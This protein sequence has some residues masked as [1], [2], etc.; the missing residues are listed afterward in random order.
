MKTSETVPHII[1]NTNVP[2]TGEEEIA[3]LNPATGEQIGSIPAGTPADA[4][5]AVKAAREAKTGW[6]RLPAAERAEFV[7]A[8]ARRMREHAREL[9]EL[10]TLENGKPFD[11]ALGGVEAG[12]GTLEQYAELGPLHRGKTLQ[13]NYMASDMMIYEPYGVA[14]A[15]VPWNDPIAIACGYLG[16]AL[17]TGNTVV[18]KP[19]EKTP[20]SAVRLVEM[21]ELPDGVLNL[22]L[23]DAR[24]GWP[25]VAHED[26]DLVL[27][28]GSVETGREIME[29]AGRQL[30]KAV[31]ELGGKD[32]I[33]VDAGVDPA[34]AAGE[35]A[36]GSFANT[37]QICTSVERIY[38]HESVADEFLR[39]LVACARALRVG[40]G[41]DPETEMGPLVDEGQRELVHRHVTQAVEAGGE[42]LCGG[43]IPDGPGFFYPPTVLSG[44][45]SGM[46]VVDEETF[47]P[48]AAV[49][50]VSSFDEA[51]EKANETTYGLAAVV[52]TPDP[53]HAARAW[54][55][56]SV[57]TVKINAVFGGAPGGAAEPRKAS[58]L[59]FGYG[60]ELLDEVTQTKVIHHAVA[61]RP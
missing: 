47:G 30:K 8:A 20:L 15:I 46:A 48:V 28:T 27:F 44:V 22:L 49:E 55:E 57:G 10:V 33:I 53:E 11:D 61:P 4:S 16:A 1:G 24:A 19:S 56:L 36:T 29:A 42:L 59:G 45:R 31:V 41:T 25:L 26:V 54:R 23:G 5:E 32:P 6:S 7:K 43:E 3:V 17:V 39:E 35:A 2:S 52:L 14:A 58:G 21:F 40:D 9:A 13:G 51:L 37:G 50:V 34:W 60:P 12:I 18:Y 38:V